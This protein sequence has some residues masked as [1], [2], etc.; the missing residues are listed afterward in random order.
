MKLRPVEYLMGFGVAA[1]WGMGMV[2]AK[3]GMEHFPPML[4]MAFRSTLTAILLLW[5]VKLPRGSL[6]WLF[7]IAAISSTLQFFLTLT[8]LKYVDVSVAAFV[9]QMEIPILLLLGVL[10]LNEKPGLRK[11]AGMIM[12]LAGVFV[13]SGQPTVYGSWYPIILLL[14]GSLAWA[15]GQIMVR[16][17]KDVD[18]LTV[19]AWTAAF[20]APQLFVSSA[21]FESGQLTAVMS[22]DWNAW[23]AVI[24]LGI[25]MTALGY[26]M[27]YTLL[28]RHPVHV[29]GPFLLT[30]PV[31]SVIGGIFFLGEILTVTLVI[32]GL[33]I[34]GGVSLIIVEKEKQ[35]ESHNSLEPLSEQ[36]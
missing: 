34:I 28:R 21:L 15:I 6:V 7:L 16:S 31:F 20:S 12:A 8:G 22:A 1:T 30:L 18:G 13:I 19:C 29:V 23:L 2:F 10:F 11:W 24:Y 36:A 4:L 33:I 35:T 26:G 5:M 14:G 17:L 3:A 27:W 32:G 25:I 9:V